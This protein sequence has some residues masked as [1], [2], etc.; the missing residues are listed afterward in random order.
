MSNS[1]IFIT[2]HSVLNI[3]SAIADIIAISICLIFLCA[4]VYRFIQIKYHGRQ[5]KIDVPLILSINILC[6]IFIKSIIQIIHVTIPT[7]MKDFQIINEFQETTFYRVRAYILW[8]II[9]VLYWSYG[10][11]AFF[12]F[13]RVFY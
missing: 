8:S 10:L 3:L 7:L 11:L 4:I 13:V 12:R 9:G 5:I 1:L 6:I 2:I